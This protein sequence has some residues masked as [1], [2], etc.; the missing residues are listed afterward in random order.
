MFFLRNIRI[1]C[2]VF[3]LFEGLES[4]CQTS[5]LEKL[6]AELEKMPEDSSMVDVLNKLSF[7]YYS[8][9]PVKSKKL[10]DR[11]LKIALQLDYHNGIAV[12]YRNIGNFYWTQGS[13]DKAL[14]NNFKS[15]AMFEEKGTQREVARCYNSIGLV[16]RDYQN[17]SAALDYTLKA[18]EIFIKEGDKERIGILLN[19][20]GGIYI[21]QKKYQEALSNLLKANK[22]FR[23]LN[24]NHRLAT[25]LNNIGFLYLQQG[26]FDGAFAYLTKAYK[27]DS[28]LNDRGRMALNLNGIAEAYRIKNDFNRSLA[29]HNNA[30]KIA[31]E[32]GVK[33]EMKNAYKGMAIAYAGSKDFES[34]YK[35]Y[36]LYHSLY[37]SLFNEMSSTK[38]KHVEA[39][40]EA[41]KKQ[42]EID[43][44]IKNKQLQDTELQKEKLIK[45]SLIGAFVA[46]AIIAFILFIGIGQK[47]KVNKKLKDQKDE[48]ESKNEDLMLK[49][50]E[51]T[52]Q[53]DEIQ[54]QRD[55]IRRKTEELEI[56]FEEINIQKEA[57]TQL[58]ATKDKFFSIVAHDIKSPLDSLSAF[59]SLLANYIDNMSKEEIRIIATNLDQSVKN[60]LQLTENLLTWARSQM[61]NLSFN[62]RSVNLAE[63]IEQKVGLF[64]LIAENKK[65]AIRTEVQEDLHLYVDEN[66]LRFILRNLI[67]NALKFTMNNGQ[68][69]VRAESVGE[70]VV[71]SV[72]DDGVGIS[73][74][75]LPKI[76][77]ID[78]KVS[79]RGTAGEK[80]TGLGLLLCKEFVER[81]GGKI[82]VE[83]E[84]AK[85]SRFSFTAKKAEVLVANS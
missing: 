73:P 18:Y 6:E 59:A 80:G 43:L 27:T 3:L 32:I 67:S 53:K 48:I 23:E 51:I 75:I 37:D 13:F 19:N 7:E 47:Q 72:Q 5:E 2:A 9:N 66:H 83:S 84:V 65:I 60:T 28:S 49:N 45:N 71:I 36:Q 69:L 17:Y 79:T 1:L 34:A 40:Y 20:I 62:P 44:L 8:P 50:V 63:V 56:A 58:N 30:L 57:L 82:K 54:M 11:A 74:D 10:A 4:Y 78:T 12:A 68:V 22:I 77:R 31:E 61:N 14:E 41:T 42:A 33:E 15:L 25:N 38:I 29:Y 21:R 39:L 85:G 81:N 24:D 26:N 35:Y 46:V 16:Y 70:Q 52:K 76:F 64:K 55:N